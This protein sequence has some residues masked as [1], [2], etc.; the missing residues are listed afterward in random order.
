MHWCLVHLRY[1]I[2]YITIS[3][4]VNQ[5]SYY[6]KYSGLVSD[7][8]FKGDFCP[9]WWYIILYLIFIFEN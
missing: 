8:Y 7:N 1:L 9:C 2:L 3:K 4:G 6:K 5:N